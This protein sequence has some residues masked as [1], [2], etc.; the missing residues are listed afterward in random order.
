[1]HVRSQIIAI[2]AFL[3]QAWF[4]QDFM[5]SLEHFCLALLMPLCLD[6]GYLEVF[7]DASLRHD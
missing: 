4:T 7:K 2:A 1:M 6:V 3:T 5:D